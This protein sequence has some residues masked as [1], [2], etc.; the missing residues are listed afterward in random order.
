[1]GTHQ[2]D[3]FC[4]STF[5]ISSTFSVLRPFSYL[6]PFLYFDSLNSR[7]C[8]IWSYHWYRSIGRSTVLV[9]VKFG[10]KS[11]SKVKDRRYENGR[12]TEKVELMRTHTI[13]FARSRPTLSYR[14]F[15]L[16]GNIIIFRSFL[17]DGNQQFRYF[18]LSGNIQFPDF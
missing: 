16:I 4:T 17:L 14:K 13:W 5:F 7:F 6:R 10:P 3:H 9:E 11:R 18:R 15:R 2:F 8:Q 1:M 12:S